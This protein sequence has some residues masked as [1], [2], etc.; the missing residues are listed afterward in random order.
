MTSTCPVGRPAGRSADMTANGPPGELE[1]LSPAIVADP[2]PAYEILRGQAPVVRV[3]EHDLWLVT[4]YQA[5]LEVLGDPVRFSSREALSGRNLFRDHA[6]AAELLRGGP[7]YPRVPTLILTDP[8]RHTRYR[9][10]VQ[11]AFAPAQTIGRLTPAIEQIVGELIDGFADRGRCDFVAEF[12]Y[13]LPMRVI[14]LVL[15][16]PADMRDTLKR[17]SD[18]F[19]AAQAGNVDAGRV[20][21]AAASTVEFE[22]YISGLLNEHAAAGDLAD[23][24]DFLSRLLVEG[25]GT[26]TDAPLTRQEQL[27]LVQQMLVGGNE[28]TTNLLGNAMA[29]LIERPEWVQR[30]RHEPGLVPGFVEEV[31]RFESPL[32]GLYRVATEGTVVQGVPLPAGAKLMVLFGSANRDEQVYQPPGFDP[33][34]DNRSSPHL[35][36]G[37]GIHACM[38]QGLARKEVAIAITR[39]TQRL[40]AIRPVPDH[41][42]RPVELFGFHGRR[43]LDIIFTSVNDDR[44]AS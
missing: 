25:A 28:T 9:R 12:A 7:G 40:T 44:R 38:G 8:P 2:Y 11:R 21:A 23:R 5:C 17:W 27:S 36:F 30:L 34:R 42:A 6:G 1:L 41:P 29:V 24:T 43:S 3:P 37:R 10:V 26:D 32:Q 22:H 14:S 35:A 19:I 31:L 33:G 13:P 20:N 15:D 18:D 16:V 39:L 4:T